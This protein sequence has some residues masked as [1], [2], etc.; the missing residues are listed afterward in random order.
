MR[1]LCAAHLVLTLTL[2]GCAGVLLPDRGIP[3]RP[4][5]VRS[6]AAR[7]ITV[8]AALQVGAEQ[9]WSQIQV[10]PDGERIVAVARHTGTMRERIRIELPMDDRLRIAVR[11]ELRDNRGRWIAS[12]DVCEHY[13]YAREREL[14][15]SIRRTARVLARHSRT[16]AQA[17]WQRSNP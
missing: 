2:S 15:E 1:R 6:P 9:G 11:S 5:V 7:P 16:L 17:P 12:D 4:L 13:T 8:V 14:A 3:Y 10:S